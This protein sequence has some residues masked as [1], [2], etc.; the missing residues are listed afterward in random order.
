MTKAGLCIVL[1]VCLCVL[2]AL[3]TPA[4]PKQVC[5]AKTCHKK[6]RQTGFKTD[7]NNCPTCAFNASPCKNKKCKVGEV[8]KLIKSRCL[9]G[10]GCPASKPTCT[11][12]VKCTIMYCFAPCPN[13]YVYDSN[14]CQTCTCNSEPPQAQDPTPAEDPAPAPTSAPLCGGDQ[15]A[16]GE[17][18]SLCGP[19]PCTP[20]CI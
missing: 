5:P 18:C 12:A 2:S 7:A 20:E 9:Y 4:K 10:F 15:C 6:C 17:T 19:D 13:G 16:E 8:C 1:I 14:N 3:A 11:P